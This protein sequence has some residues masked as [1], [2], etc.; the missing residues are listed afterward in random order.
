MNRSEEEFNDMKH[1]LIYHIDNK[2]CFILKN[3]D[4]NRIT[5]AKY[6]K[7]DP[8]VF[9]MLRTLKYAHFDKYD[10]DRDRRGEYLWIFKREIWSIELY[11]K[12]KLKEDESVV[13]SCHEAEW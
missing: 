3:R 6:N 12:I 9:E 8:D 2:S 7:F 11:I 1:K 10:E 13:I 4:K 5:L